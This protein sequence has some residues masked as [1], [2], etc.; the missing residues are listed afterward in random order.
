VVFVEELPRNITGKVLNRHL[1]ENHGQHRGKRS[2]GA[3][4]DA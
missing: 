2:H 1:R 3:H 4:P